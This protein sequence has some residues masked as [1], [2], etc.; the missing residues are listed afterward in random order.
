MLMKNTEYCSFRV[1]S[2]GNTGL[3]NLEVLLFQLSREFFVAYK[4][5]VDLL[6]RPSH[7]EFTLCTGYLRRRPF[8]LSNS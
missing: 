7:L 4:H 6:V 5:S 1:M 8:K 3:I 2:L